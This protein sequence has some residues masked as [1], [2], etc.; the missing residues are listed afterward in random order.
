MVVLKLRG[1]MSFRNRTRNRS[2]KEREF[3][4]KEHKENKELEEFDQHD[5]G[6]RE[7][8]KFGMVE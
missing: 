7:Y 6:R 1:G 5:D 2:R 3:T 8:R 4:A